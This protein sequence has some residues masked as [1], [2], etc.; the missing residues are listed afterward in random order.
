VFSVR[1]VFAQKPTIS[2]FLPTKGS[3]GS[4]VIISGTNFN[5][6][7]AN[8]FVYFGD[9]KANVLTAT[10]TSIA[11]V[12]PA[13]ASYKPISVTVNNLTAYSFLPF[14][15]TFSGDHNDFT[16]NSF[17]EK[18]DSS[19]GFIANDI[20]STDL[21]GD[22]DV[23][24]V[25]VN[26]ASSF[27]T[28]LKNNS[29]IGSISL[30]YSTLA[31]FS[32]GPSPVSISFGDL[33]G[34]TKQDIIVNCK[35]NG[36]SIFKNS[37]TIE[38]IQLTRWIDL[39]TGSSPAF[40]MVSDIDSD[41]KP[42]IVCTNSGSNNISV[43][44]NTSTPGVIS[45]ASKIDFSTGKRPYGLTIADI[46]GD[47][48][49]ELV[50][51]NKDDFSVSIFKNNSSP[52]TISLGTKTDITNINPSMLKAAD[53]DN[54]DKPE[55]IVT[56]DNSSSITV[57][58]NTSSPGSFSF[59]AAQQLHTGFGSPTYLT[60]GDID[61]DGKPDIAVNHDLYTT[62]SIIRNL[63]VPG[64]ISFTPNKDFHLGAMSLNILLTDLDNDARPDLISGNTTLSAL[65]IFRNLVSK[66]FIT[67]F[68]PA[69]GGNGTE[70]TITGNNFSTTSQVSFGGSPA[71]SFIVQSPT[72]ILAVVDTGLTGDV[73]VT[74][75]YG[76]SKISGFNFRDEPTIT[77]FSP[78]QGDTGTL[79]T[80]NGTNLKNVTA[81]NF[82]S[83][84]ATTFSV[85]SP[86]TIVATV[87]SLPPGNFEV[88][89][90]N[91]AG[92][93]VLGNFYTG[94]TISS[95]YPGSGPVGTVVTI[96]GTHF[97]SSPADN[98]VYFGSVRATVLS[99]TPTSLSVSV[100][101][102]STY[103]PM[104][105]TVSNLT[106]YSAEPFKVTF[107]GAGNG[108][109]D[110]SFGDRVDSSAGR[111]PVH[112]S[113]ADL[114]NDGKSDV[115]VSNFSS[116]T[117]SVS[118]NTSS[119]GIISFQRKVDYS[120]GSRSSS[121][122]DLNGDGKPDI[123]V[124][125]GQSGQGFE[126]SISVYKNISTTD[127][128]FLT[129]TDYPI[130]FLSDSP[131]YSVIT[132]FDRDGRPDVALLTYSSIVLLGN[133]STGNDISFA[134]KKEFLLVQG[135]ANS[136]AVADVDGDNKPDIVVAASLSDKMYI[137]RN[138]SK[139][140]QIS[141][142]QKV[143][144]ETGSVPYSV[145]LADLDNDGRPDM[146]GLNRG[147]NSLSTYK[148][149]SNAGIIL[150]NP[151][152]N[153]PLGVVPDNLTPGDL[154]GDGRTDIAF[155]TRL[156]K[157]VRVMRNTSNGAT[158]S[159]A[160]KIEYD[161]PFTPYH[162][163]LADMNNDGKAD[164]VASNPADA[165]SFSVLVNKCLDDGLAFAPIKV[166]GSLTF[167]EGENVVLS[168][169]QA[170]GATYQW[171][172]NG[173]AIV[174]ANDSTLVVNTA[175]I[176]LVRVNNNGVIAASAP[177]IVSVKPA[178]P[179]PVL[180]MT[181]TGNLC[182]G[183]AVLLHSST[184][185]GIQW[186]KDDILLAGVTDFNYS[187]NMPG[188]YKV[189]ANSNGCYSSSSNEL[190]IAIRSIPAPTIS[191]TSNTGCDG[192][193]VILDANHVSGST[194]QWNINGEQLPGA[195]SPRL[196]AKKGGSFSVTES[197]NGCSATSATI[198]ITKAPSPPKPSITLSGTSLYSSALNGNQWFRDGVAIT[199]ATAQVFT[200][201]SSGN[202]SIQVVQNGCKSA[203]SEPY[204]FVFT[205]VV[206]I[207][208]AHFIKLS[209]NPVKDEMILDFK[210]EGIYQLNIDLL[211]LNGRLVKQWQRQK[212][213]S[214]LYLADCAKS[215]YVARIY[216]ANGKV[217]AA[218]KLIRQ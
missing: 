123:V 135:L 72:T 64:T 198:V 49:V 133:T 45:F 124:S 164:I 48:V 24:P 176:F 179:T 63:S 74:T 67:S 21:D 85:V 115:I 187:V 68:S 118:K 147:N 86:T 11:V 153:Y 61:G 167:C 78:T 197:N 36:L 19:W 140:G 40:S 129:R 37:S 88:S 54:D 175:G 148:N 112:A 182:Q 169:S 138:I 146:V 125:S 94:V 139:P 104:T 65:S 42:D 92:T 44:R 83:I 18:M 184:P 95:F 189:I 151:R 142:A 102:G 98:I 39:V 60:I 174:L 27:I 107:K 35:A 158:I 8:N 155:V 31:K 77:W 15:V 17:S 3:I 119:D 154:D 177:Y 47:G 58:R 16:A 109:T 20:G 214:R 5:A 69:T 196:S 178:A 211:D 132:D 181:G 114:N 185:T 150:F 195:I 82:G 22:G 216:S 134:P 110:T 38:S 143:E 191:V 66:P 120:P 209:P 87:G 100:P 4:T 186:Y 71:S 91:A 163:V 199:G 89:V 157:F 50:V 13:G 203:M 76:V 103:Q 201:T 122:G 51:G 2:A 170:N 57:L 202:Y 173:A 212:N 213:R 43:F 41:G 90:I 28:V 180:T 55:L 218:L 126:Y 131:R 34:D 208:N 46:D 137:L 205:A 52:G 108:F 207:D 166:S 160:D 9:V 156:D 192:D 6:T 29:S 59:A 159:F 217:I 10:T 141:L 56:G 171:Y 99:A 75:A 84:A 144:V 206:F 152:V 14:T 215:V 200:P 130:G 121:I 32:T 70:V 53:L 168:T 194:Y 25:I 1:D 210:L 204:T 190:T 106:A 23:D 172:K 7:A 96:K 136:M 80:I 73:T 113:I 81:V 97:S 149:T 188:K 161:D 12:V 62:I 26:T 117:L 111:F 145:V 183:T 128:I 93:A 105:V 30:S 79:V 193:S 165:N 116:G 33:D 101:P 127:S 162:V